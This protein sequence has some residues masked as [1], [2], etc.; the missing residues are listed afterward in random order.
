MQ[1]IKVAEAAA[2]LTYSYVLHLV[3]LLHGSSSS[4]LSGFYEASRAKYMVLCKKSLHLEAGKS[5]SAACTM[6]GK[7]KI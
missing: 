7:A 3:P 5:R 4:F 6:G 1:L 2:S